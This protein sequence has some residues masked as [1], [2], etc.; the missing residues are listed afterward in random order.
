MD[1]VLPRRLS[2]VVAP[3]AG[4]SFASWVDRMAVR[5]RC[6][7][8]VVAMLLGLPLRSGSVDVK[9]LAFGIAVSEAV[10]AA[11]QA[12]TGV[13]AVVTR[14]MQLQAFDGTALDLSDVV[15]GDELALRQIGIREWAA[16]H[17]SRAC[18]LC[19]GESGGVWQLWWK[20][21]WAAACL[22][23]R[24]LLVDRCCRCGVPLRRGA[25]RH[26]L[27]LSRKRLVDPLRCEVLT[28][29]GR[30]GQ[31]LSSLPVVPVGA[32]LAAAQRRL[33]RAA[34][35][36]TVPPL[37]GRPVDAREWFAALRA[38]A[39]LCRLAL[40]HAADALDPMPQ[41]ARDALL[42]EAKERGRAGAGPRTYLTGPPHSAAA[43]AGLLTVAD[44][45]LAAPYGVALTRLLAPLAHAA[46]ER[47][48]AEGQDPVARLEMPP[49]LRAALVSA[50][51]PVFRVARPAARR[52]GL[53]P[54]HLPALAPEADYRELIAA[55]LPGT[56]IVS[57]RR[58]AAM[59]LARRAVGASSWARCGALVG[60]QQVSAVRLADQLGRRITDPAR[61]WDDIELLVDRLVQA[62]PV[63]YGA[64]RAAL[65][66]LRTIPENE[67]RAM[68]RARAVVATAQRAGHAA[69]W[70]WAQVTCGDWRDAPAAR[71]PA[72]GSESLWSSRVDGYRQFI[73]WLPAAL[74]EDLRGYGQRLLRPREVP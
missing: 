30:C 39:V 3:V 16:F 5:N 7:P 20:L 10:C 27:G 2:L 13:Q 4:E 28:A 74:A 47:L 70:V 35:G 33:L 61:F 31:E 73:V 15:L 19:L 9:P 64:R 21:G 6:P 29:S 66:G 41:P 68:T 59:A 17:A 60:L 23:H 49:V 54:R 14:A 32:P 69:A 53:H 51:R 58:F 8:G 50:R 62:G 52:P 25:M 1:D 56:A 45:I 44:R 38:V 63:D 40:P 12:A 57:G 72:H 55:H 26:P 71:H 11:V 65:E 24:V 18:P 36:G 22:D 46:Q 43:A 34:G 48:R 37:A 67:W 42:A